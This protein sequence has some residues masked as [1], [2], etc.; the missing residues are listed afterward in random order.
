MVQFTKFTLGYVAVY[1]V[2]KELVA[3][4][5]STLLAKIA[6]YL[7]HMQ[8]EYICQCILSTH[9]VIYTLILLAMHLQ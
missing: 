9:F 5:A 7:T 8:Q 4:T 3:T 6:E 1:Y 2:I